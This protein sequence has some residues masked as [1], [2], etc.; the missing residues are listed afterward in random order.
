MLPLIYSTL[1][2]PNWS[3]EQAADAAVASGYVGLEVRVLDGDIIPAE[4]PAERRSAMRRIMAER[5]LTIAAL[6]AS[7]RFSAAD[8]AKRAENEAELIRY[9]ELAIDL[10]SPMV[11]TFGGNVEAGQTLAQTIDWVAESLGRVAPVAERLGVTVLLETHDAFCRAAEVAPVLRQV[12]S[13]AV[14]AVW[15]I[16]HPFRMGESV[17][18]TWALLKPYT[19]HVHIKDARLRPDGSWQL[20]LLGEGEVPARE[21]VRLLVAEGYQGYLS[22]EWEK[23]WHPEIE[24]PEIALPQHA[25]VLRKWLTEGSMAAQAT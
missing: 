10:E 16:H 24:E 2:C 4:L 21:I 13:P 9:L 1:G 23:K 6:G 5:G 12:N 14:Q 20:V 15:D 3:L 18:Q 11:R 8:P 22:A 7:T 19:R 25:E 17:A